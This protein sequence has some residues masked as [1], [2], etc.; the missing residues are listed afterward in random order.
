MK[1]RYNRHTSSIRLKHKSLATSLIITVLNLPTQEKI[2]I[3][4]SEIRIN[5]LAAAVHQELPR[6]TA[7]NGRRKQNCR[8]NVFTRKKCKYIL[9]VYIIQSLTTFTSYII[10]GISNAHNHKNVQC[11]MWYINYYNLKALIYISELAVDNVEVQHCLHN[12]HHKKGN[13]TRTLI[14]LGPVINILCTDMEMY[15]KITHINKK[16]A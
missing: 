2:P 8:C 15:V 14:N 10:N 13:E 7:V 4:K 5:K 9:N 3:V 11:S 12:I 16:K 1:T 6:R